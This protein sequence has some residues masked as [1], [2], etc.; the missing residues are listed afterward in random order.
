MSSKIKK[1]GNSLGVRIPKT[2]IKEADLDENSEVE[3]QHKNGNIIIIP[4][5]KKYVLSDLLKKITKKNLHGE[6]E[7]AV[8][9]NEVW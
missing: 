1:W 8:E 9:G 4:I 2:I 3:I 6:D 5:Q 7:F